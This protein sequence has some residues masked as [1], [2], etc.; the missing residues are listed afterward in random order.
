MFRRT[1]SHWRRQCFRYHPIIGWW[2]IPNLYARLALGGTFHIFRTNAEGLRAD[3]SYPLRKPRG[4]V[5]I[6]ALGDSYAAGDGV[7]NGYRA[8]D[9]L[10]ARYPHL[11]VMN[12]G[13]NGSG[14]DQQL[15]IFETMAHAYEADAYIWF[16]CVEN[17][18]RN[19][20]HCFPSFN[21]H[22][23]RVRLRAKPFFTLADDDLVLHHT[24][25]PT[26]IRPMEARG[27]WF[28]GFPYLP[29]H[30]DDPYAI[31][32]YPER[33]PWQL[34]RALIGRLLRQVQGKPTFLVPLPM[35]QHYLEEAPP[36]YLERFKEL[37]SPAEHVHVIDVLPALTAWPMKARQDF[38]FADDPHY[39]N[40]AHMLV[41]DS[42]GYQMR[43]LAPALFEAPLDVAGARAP[44]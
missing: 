8:T 42:I 9:I 28:Y 41:A 27:D 11:D 7:S 39:T 44:A 13:L 24:P 10:E 23:H 14:T 22:E 34:M 37:E 18:G 25:V 29:E 1:D 43:R 31:Y 2:H 20:Y 26:D 21:F 36:I 4:R 3:S 40:R 17:I 15:L 30:P 19:Q 16:L 5:R 12:F 32:R 38:R 6:C 35:Y 33:E